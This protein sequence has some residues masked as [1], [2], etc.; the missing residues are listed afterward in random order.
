MLKS[1]I[2]LIFTNH[3]VAE[4]LWP[5]IPLLY[6]NYNIDIFC[7]GLFS[8][9]T[10]WVGDIDERVLTLNRYKKYIR[11]IINGPGI[12]F[13]GDTIN[14][15]LVD[16]VDIACYDF[17]IYDDDRSMSEFN[18]PALY[19]ECKRVGIPVIGNMHGNEDYPQNATGIS[20]DYKIDFKTGGIPAN[21]TLGQAQ[22]NPK[23]ILIITNFLSNRNS[24]FPINFD[25][26]FIE[27]SNIRQLSDKYN[28]PIKVKIKTRLDKPDYWNDIDYVKSMLDCDVIVNTNDIDQL[29][30]ESAVVIAAPSTLCFK[31]IQLGI[32]TIMILGAGATG[33]FHKYPGLVSLSTDDIIK[34]INQQS[35]NGK[36]IKYI[37]DT[38][39]Q[40]STF[41]SS[42]AYL[43]QLNK[44]LNENNISNI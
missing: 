3:R 10:P 15:S 36:F 33:A 28:L 30:A 41:K 32:P 9:D 14:T 22:L 40:G 29:I 7:V 21:D 26:N 27:R 6:N 39:A 25:K 13:H 44:L 37:D 42:Y 18:I 11:T 31:P 8:L 4:K 23:H 19:A 24:I 35:V 5:I 16:Y 12:Q 1:N 38:I 17:V 34:S 43:N 20:Y 2:L